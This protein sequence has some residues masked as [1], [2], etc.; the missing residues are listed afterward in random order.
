MS[1]YLLSVIIPVLNNAQQFAE[2]IKQLSHYQQSDMEIIVIDGG[3]NDDTLNKILQYESEI[4]YW[5]TGLDTSISDAFN[6]GIQQAKGEIIAILNSDDYWNNDTLKHVFNALEANPNADI[7]YGDLRFIDQ[8]HNRNYIKK[9]RLSRMKYRMNIYH[10]AMFI[11]RSAYDKIGLYR[12]DYHYA[13]DSEWCHRALN[14]N[15]H[16]H[17]I[18][19]VLASMR[20]GGISDI[21]FK[22]SMSEYKQSVVAHQ[23]TSSFM[24]EVYFRF[25]LLIR[26]LMNNPLIW[27]LI[28]HLT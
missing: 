14:E 20:L 7:Y 9:A 18:P 24:A 6:R 8:Q 26:Y 1:H 13:M 25:F 4:S 22:Q 5:E 21:Y 11:K 2:L 15:L 19:H 27:K 23:L 3:S 17:Y 12:L 10:P 16:F 28:R